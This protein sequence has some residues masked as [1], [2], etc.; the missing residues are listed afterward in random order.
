MFPLAVIAGNTFVLKPSER[1]PLGVV[2]LA[3][4]FLEA[5]FPTGV[6]N[7]VHGAKEAV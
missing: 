2:R 7:V 4:L 6:L 5:G 1:T 3:E